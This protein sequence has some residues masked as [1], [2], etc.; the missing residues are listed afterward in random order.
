M[1]QLTFGRNLTV[2]GRECTN[3]SQ[4]PTGTKGH[5]AEKVVN[6]YPRLDNSIQI[7]THCIK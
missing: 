5:G 3:R 1:L 6:E 7:Q 4:N 2:V